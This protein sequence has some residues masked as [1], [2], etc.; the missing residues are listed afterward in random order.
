MSR[1]WRDSC[2]PIIA[3]VL[4]ENNGKP[5]SVIKKALFDAYP[6]G[7]RQYHPYKIWL[8]EIKVQTGKK[9]KTVKGRIMDTSNNYKL[10]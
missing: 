8:D 10:F 7:V 3:K 1:T 6:F 9:K 5:E 2:R 4:K